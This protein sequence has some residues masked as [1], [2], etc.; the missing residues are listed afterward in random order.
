M[1]TVEGSNLAV[2]V[3]QF[4]MEKRLQEFARKLFVPSIGTFIPT[5]G[6]GM[7]FRQLPSEGRDL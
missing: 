4:R 3:L 1:D 2:R 5:G 6:Q 7:G